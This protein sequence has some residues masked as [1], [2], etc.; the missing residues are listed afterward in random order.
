M[1]AA[2]IRTWPHGKG[3]SSRTSDERG[4]T[5]IEVLLSLSILVVMIGL[6]LSALRLGQRSMEKGEK[7][8]DDAAVRRFV[9]KR[10]S[11]DVSSMYLYA[12][13]GS[14]S[15]NNY[16]FKGQDRQLGFV[17]TYH[18]GSTGMPWGGASYV[19]YS[20]G[21]KGLT[22]TE[23]T[24]PFAVVETRQEGRTF[25]LGP[26]ISGV[27][28]SYLG[29]SGWRNRWNP[30]VQKRLPMAVRA[31]FSLRDGAPLVVTVPVWA[32]YDPGET[33]NQGPGGAEVNAG[34]T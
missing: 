18:A 27:R 6:V 30:A 24:L 26:S 19:I 4:F 28:F 5:L 17:T 20:V 14:G 25:E 2:A 22:I 3:P 15:K 32:S 31:E 13:S 23:K 16:L 9:V 34:K 1:N 7:A 10:L 21:E 33:G 11:S 8:M 12:V 29:E